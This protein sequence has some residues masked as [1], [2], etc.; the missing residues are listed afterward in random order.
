MNLC[1]QLCALAS[2]EERAVCDVIDCYSHYH[3]ESEA[4]VGTPP[5]SALHPLHSEQQQQLAQSG[6]DAGISV[7][8]ETESEESGGCSD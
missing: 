5:P 7:R 4:S 1:S 2:L 3:S 8:R 6:E